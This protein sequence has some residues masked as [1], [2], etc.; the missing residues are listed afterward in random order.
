[1]TES[2]WL[3]STDPQAMLQ[4]LSGKASDRKLRLFACACVRSIR[5]HLIEPAGRDALQVSERYADGD[6]SPRQLA[7]AGRSAENAW[8]AKNNAQP[9][10]YAL[11]RAAGEVGGLLITAIDA[12]KSCTDKEAFDTAW[13]ANICAAHVTGRQAAIL[14]V[15][16]TYDDPDT[17]V[18]E[19]LAGR[20]KQYA[21]QSGFLHDI[22]G[23]PFRPM[24]ALPAPVLS[25]HDRLVPRLAQSIYDERL[26]PEGTLDNSRLAILSGAL[27]DASCKDETLLGHLW[28]PGPHV[29]GCFAVDIILGRS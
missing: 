18:R 27:L 8:T 5:Q 29:R 12:A 1:M 9:Q 28:S 17:Y 7:K 11:S 3:A 21:C 23:N 22:I 13:S 26:L 4:F 16:A 15:P 6:A 24:P 25:W 19:E 2:E 14:A 20:L 10:A